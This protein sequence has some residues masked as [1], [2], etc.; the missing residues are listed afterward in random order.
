MSSTIMHVSSDN[1]VNDLATTP[2]SA[3]ISDIFTAETIGKH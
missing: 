2:I 3:S 1:K